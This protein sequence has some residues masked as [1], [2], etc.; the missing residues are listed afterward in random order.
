MHQALY[1]KWRPQTFDDVCGQ[2]HITSVLR[3]EVSQNALS[4]AYLF[5]GSRGTGKTT[6]AKILAKAV[7]CLSPVDGSPCGKCAACLSIDNGSATDVLEMD[8]ASNNGVEN[9]RDIRDE[10]VYTPS[11]LRYRVYIVDEVHMLS[12]SAFNALLKTLEEP[13]SHVIFILATTELHKLP[14]T[15]VSRCQ[16]FDF[17]RISLSVL[18]A[19]I[20][21]IAQ[22]EG[23]ELE[24]AA[25][26]RIARMA[27][28]G[29]RDAI[30][31]LELCGGTR[32]KIDV[33]T[34]DEMMGSGGREEMLSIV[35]AIAS[36]DYDAIF[37]TVSEA[38][39]SSRDLTVFWQDLISVYRD[40]LVVKTASNATNYLD[41]TDTETAKLTELAGR[42]KKGTLLA[43]CHLLEDALF[44]MQSANAVKRMIAELTLVRMCDPTLDTSAEGLLARVERL[45]DAVATGVP[46]ISA[47]PAKKTAPVTEISKQ[48]ASVPVA[49][50]A[51]KTTPAASKPRDTKPSQTA[52]QTPSAIGTAS[53]QAG[54][55]LHRIRGFM[56]CVERV[57]REDT[58]A[59]SFLTDA[60][61]F[62]DESEQV[63]LQLSNSFAEMMLNEPSTKELL[64]RAIA[65]ELKKD[66]STVKLS[67]EIVDKEAASNDTVLDD[68][69]DAANSNE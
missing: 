32:K 34:V 20:S 15:I 12:Q 8:A 4:H 28:G 2:D 7:N 38:V 63:V 27:Q 36:A 11:S 54:R 22:Q 62:L 43:H 50:T 44:A 66:A 14:A 21:Y 69:L 24:P 64:C 51:S 39:A 55:V 33:A 37:A 46:V 40:L 17:R 60:R 30:S 13:P 19:R 41:L 3:Y 45:E 57:R 23:M 5:C 16:R 52:S 31:L 53:A 67:I 65:A 1:R 68:L 58:M 18:A 9:I 29:M 10:V 35:E 61:A 48:P 6:C 42:F 59:A 26:E 25:A 49:P 56:N 47:A